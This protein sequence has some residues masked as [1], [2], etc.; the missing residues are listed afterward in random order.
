[1]EAPSARAHAQV[2]LSWILF[3]HSR[4][5]EN[6]YKMGRRK[7]QKPSGMIQCDM[8]V[9]AQALAGGLVL[10]YLAQFILVS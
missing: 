7:M 9:L 10:L 1:M 3:P 2:N 5:T 4:R 6:T 8:H